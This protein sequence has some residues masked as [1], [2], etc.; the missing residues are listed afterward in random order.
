MKKTGMALLI[1]CTFPWLDTRA[2]SDGVNY[3]A[4]DNLG[5]S[6]PT[7]E[8]VGELRTNKTVAMFFWTWHI[9]FSPRDKACDLGKILE[10][11]SANPAEFV[12]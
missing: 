9:N 5:R 6:L 3:P 8:E 1:L 2:Q 7:Y 11:H 10:G 4:T 12:K